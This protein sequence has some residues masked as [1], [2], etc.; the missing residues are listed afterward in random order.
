[1]GLISRVSSRTYRE[2]ST[3]TTM[4]KLLQISGRG[5]RVMGRQRERYTCKPEHAFAPKGYVPNYIRFMVF[6]S[7]YFGTAFTT[8]CIHST[9]NAKYKEIRNT[10]MYALMKGCP[11]KEGYKQW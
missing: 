1:M 4:F 5:L 9:T 6:C 10:E 2:V 8:H 3:T 7:F 11:I